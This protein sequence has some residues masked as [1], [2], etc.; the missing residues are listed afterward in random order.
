MDLTY[1]PIVFMIKPHTLE[2]FLVFGKSFGEK[3][4]P[5]NASKLEILSSIGVD[6]L[7]IFH[8][9]NNN[10]FIILQP[11]NGSNFFTA[12]DD[13]VTNQLCPRDVLKLSPP[14]STKYCNR[15]NY[16]DLTTIKDFNA[17]VKFN[18]VRINV[19]RQKS[20]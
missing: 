5:Q 20:A 2:G 11:T 4:C 18:N 7:L 9:I 6:Q 17:A 12:K 10:I 19:N 16:E 15:N 3:G 14:P 8:F 13:E 1:T